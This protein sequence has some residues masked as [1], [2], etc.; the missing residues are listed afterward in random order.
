MQGHIYKVPWARR[1]K[2]TGLVPGGLGANIVKVQLPNHKDVINIAF[3][4][5]PYWLVEIS[6]E[7]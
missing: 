3:V 2:A 5:L 1:Q 7:M 4:Q 6:W